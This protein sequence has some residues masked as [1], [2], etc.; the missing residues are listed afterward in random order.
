MLEMALKKVEVGWKA[1]HSTWYPNSIV[2]QERYSD[3]FKAAFWFHQTLQSNIFMFLFETTRSWR[4]Y[5][6]IND[7]GGEKVQKMTFQMLI[8]WKI[9]C[10]SIKFSSSLFSIKFWSYIL[11]FPTKHIIRIFWMAQSNEKKHITTMGKLLIKFLPW[12]NQ[13]PMIIFNHVVIWCRWRK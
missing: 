11:F 8:I 12:S 6:I 4:L 7:K 10:L 13:L 1:K 5:L 3:I 2:I 9:L